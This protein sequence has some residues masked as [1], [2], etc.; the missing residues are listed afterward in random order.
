[1]ATPGGVETAPNSSLAFSILA[2][3]EFLALLHK[4]YQEDQWM[5]TLLSAT[6]SMHNLTTTNGLWFLNDYLIIPNWGHLCEMLFRLAHDN[7]GHFGFNKSYKTLHH[8]YYWPKMRRD[9]EKAYAPSC[10]ECQRNKSS[11]TK[12]IS[13]FHPLPIPDSQ[14][15]SVAINFIGP[16]PVDEGFNSIVTFTNCLG[17]DIHILPCSTSITA[18]EFADVL[19]YNWYCKNGLPLDIISDRNRLFISHFWQVLHK[20]TGVKLKLSMSFHSKTDGASKH[21]NKTVNQCIHFYIKRNQ[22]GWVKT[23]PLICFNLINTVK[24]STTFSLFQLHTYGALTTYSPP[25][26]QHP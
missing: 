20:L 1:V 19:F 16:L 26:G 9:L 12:P 3:K 23:L 13:L 11:T 14:G 22:T 2:D 21:T 6:P 15:N 24:K 25:V 8:T 17:A 10:A 7:L 18:E 5:R 4:E